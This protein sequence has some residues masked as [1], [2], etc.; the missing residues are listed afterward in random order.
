[1]V[2]VLE[3]DRERTQCIWLV[4]GC[5]SQQQQNKK[6]QSSFSIL[7]EA[8]AERWEGNK[9]ENDFCRVLVRIVSMKFAQINSILEAVDILRSLTTFSFLLL[10]YSLKSDLS[11]QKSGFYCLRAL[12]MCNAMLCVKYIWYHTN[13]HQMWFFCAAFLHIWFKVNAS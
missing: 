2:W 8:N 5:S 9:I 1:M 11:M 12:T 13:C 10:F 7:I 4:V 6:R 3:K